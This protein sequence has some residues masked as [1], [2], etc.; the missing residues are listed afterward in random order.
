M[1]FHVTHLNPAISSHWPW[2]CDWRCCHSVGLPGNRGLAAQSHTRQHHQTEGGGCLTECVKQCIS[3]T[4]MA[5]HG[6]ILKFEIP[7][8][9]WENGPTWCQANARAARSV[10]LVGPYCQRCLLLLW[11]QRWTEKKIEEM[12]Y[13]GLLVSIEANRTLPKSYIHFRKFAVLQC[14]QTYSGKSALSPVGQRSTSL[15]SMYFWTPEYEAGL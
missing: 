9:P 12:W 13:Q 8:L 15:K 10:L 4:I 6:I 5:I 11:E 7:A 2:D 1:A 3:Q 14:S